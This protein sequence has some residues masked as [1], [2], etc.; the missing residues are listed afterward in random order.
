MLAIV[1]EPEGTPLKEP[2]VEWEGND[3]L[4]LE[5]GPLAFVFFIIGTLTDL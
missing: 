5:L 2:D 4:L 1:V 3:K